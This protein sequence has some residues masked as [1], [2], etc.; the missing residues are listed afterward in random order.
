VEN[1]QFE[2]ISVAAPSEQACAARLLLRKWDLARQ[3]EIEE[4]SVKLA[5]PSLFSIL[6]VAALIVVF[7]SCRILWDNV[8]LLFVI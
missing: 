8:P 5:G 6:V 4:M 3:S 7:H 2:L 1:A